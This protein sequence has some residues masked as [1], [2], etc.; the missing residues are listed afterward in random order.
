MKRALNIFAEVLALPYSALFMEADPVL[1]SASDSGLCDT[2]ISKSDRIWSLQQR[3]GDISFAVAGDLNQRTEVAQLAEVQA[4][5]NHV[6]S[7]R[8]IFSCMENHP[9]LKEAPA[10][11][12]QYYIELLQTMTGLLLTTRDGIAMLRAWDKFP[13]SL[14]HVRDGATHSG[15]VENTG[16][17][18]QRI[19]LWNSLLRCLP[20]DL[21]LSCYAAMQTE[22]S[23][24]LVQQCQLSLQILYSFGD[25][26]RI[27]DALLDKVL[28][29]G[30]AETHMHAFAYHSFSMIWEDM[31][32]AA[33]SSKELPSL[34]QILPYK[35][36]PI[37][38]IAIV[39]ECAVVRLLLCSYMRSGLSSIMTFLT[40][41]H[42]TASCLRSF[43]DGILEIHRSGHPASPISA[44][45]KR[46][47]PFLLG[48]YSETMDIWN[49]LNLPPELRRARPTLAEKSFLCW[50]LLRI[51]RLPED[52]L[53]TSIFLYYLRLRSQVYR[54]RV[55]D[56]RSTGLSYFQQYY[57]ASTDP[58]GV[59]ST[60]RLLEI[61]FAT[62]Q[63]Q[64]VVKT[65]FRLSPPKA[66]SS[67]MM[68]AVAEVENHLQR[69][70]LRFIKH[71]LY[72]IVLR[73]SDTAMNH[74]DLSGAYQ[75]AWKN[76][77][78][79]LKHGERHVLDKLLRD[80]GIEPRG[81]H[82]HRFGIV[83]HLIKSGEKQEE[84]SCFMSKVD[85]SDLRQYE[86]FSFGH[87]R[88][89]YQVSVM[90]ISNLRD[91]CPAI[92]RL[93]IGLDAA[94]LEIPTEPWVFAPSF[95]EAR[96]RNATLSRGQIVAKNKAL[97]GLTYHVGED[98][99]HPI[100]GLRHME[101]AIDYLGM[102]PGDRIGHGLAMSIDID[103]WY[104]NHGLVVMP[105]QEWLEN[106]L[107]IWQLSTQHPELCALTAYKST[108]QKE[109]FDC[110]REIYGT[111]NGI[112]LENL[113]GAYRAK[114]APV[115]EINAKVEN[116]KHFCTFQSDCISSDS[117]EVIYP[118]W[119]KDTHPMP[120]WTEDALI[121]S[122]HCGY[123]KQR[124]AEM[125]LISPTVAQLELTKELQRY[126]KEKVAG[127][128]IIIE[129]NP[130]SNA[131][132]GEMDG[133]LRHPIWELREGGVPHVMTTVNTDDPSV[134]NATVANEHAQVYYALRYHG[135]S[136]E[137]ALNDVDIIRETGLRAS[138][139]DRVSSFE[140][141]LQDYESIICA[142]LK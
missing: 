78:E 9:E 20:E 16:F 89:H 138:F 32:S 2:R 87:A 62:L 36:H 97:L 5:L 29:K 54:L 100:S 109:I 52:D 80:F 13:H 51:R 76:V 39:R 108:A 26:V 69:D 28:N 44:A 141:T 106:N 105:R 3:L 81:V 104:S 137:D 30:M 116:F 127:N 113:F 117:S 111:L 82:A 125:I 60:N 33:A 12:H 21:F 27:A 38:P 123:Y 99:R 57:K 128:G 84:F 6:F 70:L 112:T 37:D 119:D 35:K 22:P 79:H 17:V 42:V 107:W 114:A 14:F 24:S 8:D 86:R 101:E 129:A 68:A 65:E 132:I 10:I 41:E 7:A 55:Q 96:R 85:R 15:S 59:S 94:S 92:S 142:L 135:M 66:T 19:E 124:M 63:D 110:A 75:Q 67:I 23:T 49:I 118:C 34:L 72:A 133:I 102:H 93:I 83:Y 25:S 61:F 45:T 88:Y 43:R 77:L 139:I 115:A 4:Y 1:H 58:A 48:T 11:L 131:T 122:H 140:Q 47:I 31:L 40:P 53:F 98:F 56:S 95:Q 134:F 130:S 90:A 126:L 50:S 74:D 73:M 46:G 91:R 103:R 120:V 18:P 136:T 71:H 64:R 121:L